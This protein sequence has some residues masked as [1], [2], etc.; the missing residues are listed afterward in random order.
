MRRWVPALL[1]I[2]ALPCVGQAQGL[3][4]PPNMVQVLPINKDTSYF[5]DAV[6]MVDCPRNE[7]EPFGLC[8][9][10]LF[11][12]LAL[13]SS[14]LQGFIQIRFFPPVNNI[15]HFEVSHPSNLQGDDTVLKAPQ[16]YEM[17]A[18][19]NFILDPFTNLSS[20]D[21]NL[22]TG[23]V[24]NLHYRVFFSNTFYTA[25]Q[26]ANPKLIGNPFDFPGGYGIA[27]AEFKQRPDGL[28]DFTFFGTTFLPL[29]GNILG[30]PV[31]IPLPF[32]G[33]LVQCGSMEAPGTSLHPR[34]RISTVPMTD[35]PC[36]ANCPDIPSNTGQTFTSFS[37]STTLGDDFRLNIPQ[38]GGLG[39]GRSHLVGRVH[40][41]FGERTGD[42]L[43]F[44]VS[45]LPPEGFLG[46][47]PAGTP[48]GFSLGM[49]GSSEFL[50]FP[51]ATYPIE[52][53]A[54]GDDPFNIAVGE[55]NLKTG[56]GVGGFIYRSFF[57]QNIA[58]A[59]ARLNPGLSALS[60]PFKGYLIFEK[61]ANGQTVFRFNGEI[62]VAGDGLVWPTPDFTTGW[63]AGPNSFFDVF[64]RL[65]MMRTID[66]PQVV[67]S[68]SASNVLSSMGDTFS[69]NYVI[70]CNPLQGP[71]SFSY[72]NSGSSKNAGTFQLQSLTSVSCINS[73]TSRAAPGDYDTV[74]FTGF[75]SWSKDSQ[76]HIAT[77][78]IST[79]PDF[80][81]VFITVDGGFTSQANTK[82]QEAP[83]P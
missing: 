72:T 28:L 21:L 82:P 46:P 44:V 40:I 51:N 81:Y 63:F 7:D 15:S 76:P 52:S 73:R 19:Q 78:Q 57:A 29:G 47:A 24:T 5:G 41:Q 32:C 61:G 39:P 77:F 70:P 30:E 37:Q 50:R 10:V 56:T 74:G 11:G 12:G 27:Q 18:L 43:P 55:L 9:N 67:K 75:G 22:R 20:G 17:P 64:Y 34:I 2:I 26:N 45:A 16:F 71:A 8:H 69:Y 58:F 42:F 25:L 38:L 1:L 49:L 62:S 60:I 53:V 80:P 33:P 59:L 48:I 54:T 4:L 14:H 68:G 36:G 83:L 31:R 3:Q 65:Q 6:R 79:S 35:P 66:S 13:M 23:E